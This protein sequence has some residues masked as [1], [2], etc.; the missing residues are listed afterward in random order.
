T[1]SEHEVSELT[2]AEH[3]VAVGSRSAD[4]PVPGGIHGV[5]LTRW[6]RTI[7]TCCAREPALRCA[8]SSPHN[9]ADS[10]DFGADHAVR[11][12]LR[13]RCGETRHRPVVGPARAVWGWGSRDPVA[14]R[15]AP[16]ES[17]EIVDHDVGDP[18]ERLDTGPTD[19]W[20][21]HDPRVGVDRIGGIG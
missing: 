21:R 19:V 7:A 17:P 4:G 12:H 14:E 11:R 18:A 3:G 2:A 1:L 15:L 8:L 16:R 9:T 20:Q 10:R 6:T 5:R 13:R